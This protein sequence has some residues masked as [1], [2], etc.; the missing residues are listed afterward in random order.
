MN[1][2]G[3]KLLFVQ[4][5]VALHNR[6]YKHGTQSVAFASLMASITGKRKSLEPVPAH[7]Q[8]LQELFHEI[9]VNNEGFLD[10][11][12]LRV[13]S[14]SNFFPILK[15]SFFAK[16]IQKACRAVLSFQ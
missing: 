15:W 13:I 6:P 3:L 2:Q 9:D 16:V 5:G 12:K 4:K 8:D 1:T 14:A 7:E 10:A 11:K